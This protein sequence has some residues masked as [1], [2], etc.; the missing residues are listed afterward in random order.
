[1]VWVSCFSASSFFFGA[2]LVQ[3]RNAARPKA[4]PHVLFIFEVSLYDDDHHHHH[5]HAT[6]LLLLLFLFMLLQLRGLWLGPS[7]PSIT[8]RRDR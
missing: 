7:I 2:G 5:H 4:S 1:M 3:A 6:S 8:R